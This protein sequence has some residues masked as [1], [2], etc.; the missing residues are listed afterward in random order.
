MRENF[1]LVMPIMVPALLGIAEKHWNK[2]IAMFI[3]NVLSFY[4]NM[5]TKLYGDLLIAHQ[6]TLI[7]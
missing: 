2:Q 3:Q 7:K 6:E 4:Q 5:N 1:A